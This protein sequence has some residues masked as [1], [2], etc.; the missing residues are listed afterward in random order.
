MPI[1]CLCFL[2]MFSD[3][4]LCPSPETLSMKCSLCICPTSVISILHHQIVVHIY[5]TKIDRFC[6]GVFLSLTPSLHPLSVHTIERLCSNWEVLLRHSCSE[7]ND[8]KKGDQRTKLFQEF[9]CPHSL[10]PFSTCSWLVA[11]RL[12]SSMCVGFMSSGSGNVFVKG[13]L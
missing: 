2:P 10:H 12:M 7:P 8:V 11:H 9:N 13:N 1:V 4:L 3:S 5:G 6:I